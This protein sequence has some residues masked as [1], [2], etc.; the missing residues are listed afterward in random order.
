MG[1]I[2]GALHQLIVTLMFGFLIIIVV[3]L[4]VWHWFQ[5]KKPVSIYGDFS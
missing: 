1:S 5:R 3:A 2:M 4:N